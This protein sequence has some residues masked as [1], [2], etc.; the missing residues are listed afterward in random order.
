MS[1]IKAL[2]ILN[3]VFFLVHLV[4]SQLTQLKLL[5]GQSIG[6]VSD[7]YP[8]LFTPAGITFSIWGLIY[9]A[10]IVFC[11]YHLLK[12]FNADATH[13]ANR[14]VQRLGYL[15]IG[16]N[17]ATGAWTIAW[18]HELLVLSV[19]LMLMQLLT[20]L[21]MQ[22]RL[23][24]FDPARSAASR[25]FTQVPLSL[26]FG[27]ICIATIANVSAVLVGVGWDGFGLSPEF[28]TVVMLVVATLLTLFVVLTRHNPFVGLVT[29]WAFYGIILKQREQYPGSYPEI[30]T[31]TWIGMALVAAAVLVILYR[32]SLAAK[33]AVTEV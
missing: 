20:L 10:L 4:P 15:F 1:K 3:A 32:N 22:L 13:E 5:S 16:N 29:L 2:A 6:D 26:Y 17:L 28:W 31:T 11:I 14:D 25:W 21:A 33:A 19:A 24:I 8:T 27:W 9:L 30:I 12:A 18:V 7:K 23:G